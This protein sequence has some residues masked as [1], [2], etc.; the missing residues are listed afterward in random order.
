[1]RLD[2]ERAELLVA[3][4]SVVALLQ[5]A[6][7]ARLR[8]DGAEAGGTDIGSEPRDTVTDHAPVTRRDTTEM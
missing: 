8:V 6:P 2:P 4:A 1:M 5:D 7:P 3:E